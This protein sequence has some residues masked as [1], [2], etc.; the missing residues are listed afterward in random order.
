MFFGAG[1]S[2]HCIWQS[3]QQQD[4]LMTT[5]VSA[6]DVELLQCRWP[7]VH[8]SRVLSWVTKGRP[9][10]HPTETCSGGGD[11]TVSC[12]F[13]R[14]MNEWIAPIVARQPRIPRT[15]VGPVLLR[16]CSSPR[17]RQR[18]SSLSRCHCDC[19]LRARYRC[20]NAKLGGGVKHDLKLHNSTIKSQDARSSPVSRSI[21]P[22]IQLLLD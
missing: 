20:V 12:R 6:A 15:A 16:W 17:A 4:V 7:S 3:Q 13:Q 10:Q 14:Q 11:E 19:W 18:I 5:K 1:E 2:R 22:S 9:Q 8:G 21:N